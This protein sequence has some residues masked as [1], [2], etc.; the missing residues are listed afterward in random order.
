MNKSPILYLYRGYRGN[1]CPSML[2]FLSDHP[3]KKDEARY[4]LIG[5]TPIPENMTDDA[6]LWGDPTIKHSRLDDSSE[7]KHASGE[8]IYP[9]VPHVINQVNL[10]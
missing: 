1:V 10:S 7:L 9:G 4:R 5:N 8:V 6:Q 2:S 3:Y